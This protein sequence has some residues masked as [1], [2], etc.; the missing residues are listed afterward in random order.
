MIENSILKKNRAGEKAITFGLNVP[1]TYV[2]ELAGHAGFDA[3]GID[4]EHGAFTPESIE[5]ICRLANAFGM[6]VTARVPNIQPNTINLYLDRGVQGIVGPHIESGEEAQALV[7]ACLFPPEGK[8]SFGGGRMLLN[9]TGDWAKYE[10]KAAY[11]KR[12]NANVIVVAQ[13][14]S[15]KAYENLDA[16][17]A[18]KGL[19]GV[20]GGPNDFAA[21]LGF[22]AQPDHPKRIAATA[23]V[24]KRARAAGKSAGIENVGTTALDLLAQK[25]RPLLAARDRT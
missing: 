5:A 13:I 21:S 18:V 2:V 8:R 14:E 20:T 16:I 11:Y 4:G 10:D 3:I 23:D 17:L 1:S 22:P 24:E 6:S 19:T 9:V 12:W 15:N 25:A 7:D